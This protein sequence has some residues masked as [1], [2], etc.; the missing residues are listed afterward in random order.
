MLNSSFDQS[1][2]V[3]STKVGGKA[4]QLVMLDGWVIFSTSILRMNGLYYV[5]ALNAWIM[6][7]DMQS[8]VLEK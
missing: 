6:L 2:Q 5:T 8:S 4:Y 7:M 1:I 3:I